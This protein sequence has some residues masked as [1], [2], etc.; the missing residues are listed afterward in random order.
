MSTPRSP[1][2]GQ[3]VY[4]SSLVSQ[5]ALGSVPTSLG[6]LLWPLAQALWPSETARARRALRIRTAAAALLQVDADFES[7]QFLLHA[8]SHSW[9]EDC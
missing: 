7:Q 4:M 9:W 8:H 6:A 1:T 2:K 3:A 5:T